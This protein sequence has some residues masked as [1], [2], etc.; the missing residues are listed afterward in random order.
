VWG[1]DAERPKPPMPGTEGKHIHVEIGGGEVKVTE[2]SFLDLYREIRAGRIA[3]DE[4]VV[5]FQRLV[6]E[7]S[8]HSA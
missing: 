8:K 3:E 7:A 4:A 1:E 5:R 6:D 2:K